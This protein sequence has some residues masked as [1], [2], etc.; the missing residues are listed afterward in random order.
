MAEHKYYHST[1]T[2]TGAGTT[3]DQRGRPLKLYSV[4]VK[5]TGAAAGAWDVSL[6]GSIDGVN[7]SEIANHATGSGD[8]AVVFS[9]EAPAM[10][11][12]ANCNSLTLGGASN[13]VVHMLGVE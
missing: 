9:T 11:F 12:R 13:I 7:F 3:V 1:F 4:Q 2:G 5:G 10:Y 6:Q 8:G